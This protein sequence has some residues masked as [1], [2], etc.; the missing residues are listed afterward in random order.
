MSTRRGAWRAVALARVGAALLA[1]GGLACRDPGPIRLGMVTGLTGRHY[2]L[3]ISSRNGATLAVEE[4]NAA[5]GVG[6][7]PVE[8]LLR[9]DRQDPEAARAAVQELVAAGV[10][11]LVGH[12][13]SA[14][15]EATLPLVDRARVLMVSPT[16]SSSAFEGKDDWFVMLHPSSAVAARALV[17]HAERA[18]LAGRF[19]IVYD[20][21]NGNFTRSWHDHFSRELAERGGSVVASVP[22][23]SGQVESYGALV[24]QAL[25]ARPEGLL[26]VANALDCASIAQQLRKRS[27]TVALLGTE[28]GFTNDV[29][30]HGGTAVE[31]ARFTQKV[32]LTGEGA[33]F[34]RFRDAYA[35]RFNRAPD[36]AAIMSYEAVQVIAEGLRRDATREGLRGA[37]LGHSFQGLQE[38]IRIDRNGD[39][40]RRH[41]LMTVRGGRMTR[42]E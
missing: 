12:A 9:D 27:A 37:V 28:W 4:L 35:A 1:C 42:L 15:A 17:T 30:A 40:V 6:G 23:T 34:V 7:R 36:F 38:Q 20:L 26:V 21:S 2:D 8:L 11:A 25:A 5:G 16:V 24:E 10:V 39:T 31:G 33:P 22:F 19:A 29:L 3:G 13:T 18:G 32:D 41:Y 14:M